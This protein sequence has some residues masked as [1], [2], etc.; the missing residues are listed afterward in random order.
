SRCAG[1]GICCQS[2]C[3]PGLRCDAQTGRCV[4]D[5]KTCATCCT[6]DCGD[7]CGPPP[8]WTYCGAYCDP[9]PGTTCQ[10]CGMVNRG[11]IYGDG[12]PYCQFLQCAPA[13]GGC[14]A[15]DGCHDGNT[16]KAC[17][18]D[19]KACVSCAAGEHCVDHACVGV[20]DGGG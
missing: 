1:G 9:G 20:S 14:Q 6:K 5:E 7:W 13:N 4:C 18:A 16:D 17:G 10:A 12:P 19:L 8:Q 11:C 15:Q 2:A 3:A